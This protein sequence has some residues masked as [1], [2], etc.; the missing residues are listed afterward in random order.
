MSRQVLQEHFGIAAGFKYNAALVK[1]G[2]KSAKVV[3]LTVVDDLRGRFGRGHWLRA[4]GDVENGQPTM[5]ERD[6]PFAKPAHPR[7]L[8]IGP[9]MDDSS[10]HRRELLG[11]R[12]A[13]HAT[14]E[15]A[16]GI[17]WCGANRDLPSIQ[18]PRLP[19]ARQ[20]VRPACPPSSRPAR[21]WTL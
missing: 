3:K 20:H 2:P 4:A 19:R 21:S 14:D 5:T 7:P 17:S 13:L 9:A 1:V 6:E 11:S 18:T 15:T 12:R 16:H 10:Q 8:P